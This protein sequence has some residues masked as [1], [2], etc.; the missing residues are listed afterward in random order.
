ML[1]MPTASATRI[2]GTGIKEIFM[3]NFILLALWL[4]LPYTVFGS[5]LSEP[6][7]SDEKNFTGCE[8]IINNNRLFLPSTLILESGCESYCADFREHFPSITNS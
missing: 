3:K 7:Y 2:V 8:I 6:Q 5:C 1:V 4:S